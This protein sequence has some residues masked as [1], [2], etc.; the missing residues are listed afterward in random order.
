MPVMAFD[1][2]FVP[3]FV[4]A[5]GLKNYW[6][7]NTHSFFSPH[8]GY[9][10]TPELGTHAH[11][12]KELVKALHNAGIGVILDVVF[13]HTA[14]GNQDGPMIT[15]FCLSYRT[16]ISLSPDAR[17]TISLMLRCQDFQLA[18]LAGCTCKTS[19]LI[20]QY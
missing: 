10:V 6:G 8:P 16:R 4:A 18:K 13:N 1:L 7:Y 3:D 5:R 12:F 20:W 17:R 9:C 14:E 15:A 19:D 2:Q 11:E